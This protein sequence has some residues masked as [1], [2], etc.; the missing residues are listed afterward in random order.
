MFTIRD[1]IFWEVVTNNFLDTFLCK[2][3]H[4]IVGDMNEKGSK[5][6]RYYVVSYRNKRKQNKRSEVPRFRKE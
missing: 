1:L 6:H 3:Y 5:S 2:V 4:E